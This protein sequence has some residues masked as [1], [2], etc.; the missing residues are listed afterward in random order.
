MKYKI[1]KPDSSIIELDNAQM[2]EKDINSLKINKNLKKY[3]KSKF[4]KGR[5]G[6]KL[7][8][9]RLAKKLRLCEPEESSDN[10]NFRW[11]PN[12]V[13][14]FNAV[15]KWCEHIALEVLD[16]YEV[17][18]PIMYDWSYPDIQT[19][20]KSFLER[21]Y[22]INVPSGKKLVL[23]FAGDFGLF[24]I[25]KQA[26]FSYK[27]L[28]LRVFEFSKSF[29][30][31]KHGELSG[32]KRPRAFHMP[33]IHSFC[34]DL[35]QA[36][37]EFEELFKAYEML[38]RQM[39]LDLAL[40]FPVVSE[41]LDSNMEQLE[42]LV[43]WL[44]RP[45]LLEIIPEMKHYWVIKG[46]F[47][48]VDAGPNEGQIST[49][50]LDIED[51]QRY[52]INYI[53]EKG[54]REACVIVHSSLGSIERIMYALLEESANKKSLPFWLAPIQICIIPISE[55]FNKDA[56]NLAKFIQSSGF[57]VIVDDRDANVN[58]K[59]KDWRKNRIPANIAIGEKEV[60][61]NSLSF[62]MRGSKHS[63]SIDRKQLISLL[64]EFQQGLPIVRSNNR[65][66]RSKMVGF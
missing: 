52:G 40:E 44:G 14:A 8:S 2:S 21:H 45:V 23:R 24:R 39:G 34:Q 35:D 48:Y 10:G 11:L 38:N 62:Q 33:D 26:Q 37:N 55:K 46:D 59:V 18:S 66:L 25:M 31:E 49:I 61:G 36:W 12:G 17:D 9:S 1:L 5:E 19:Q 53:D 65:L 7:K 47:H 41:F 60:Q 64:D 30:Y 4:I 16:A 51:A 20:G 32:L 57:R 56:I 42:S 27:Q 22:K 13:V 58:K 54:K 3:L 63:R 6:Q 29:R 43:K 28:P 15:K 50:Q